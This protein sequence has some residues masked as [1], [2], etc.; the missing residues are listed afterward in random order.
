MSLETH[1]RYELI[2]VISSSI[3]PNLGL[4]AVANVVKC[5][6]KTVKY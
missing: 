1:Q 6:K 5:D 2:F 3:G 4:E